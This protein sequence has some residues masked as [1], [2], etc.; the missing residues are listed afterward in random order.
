MHLSRLTAYGYSPAPQIAGACQEGFAAAFKV[1]NPLFH[2]HM[3]ALM[4]AG[5][6]AKGTQTLACFGGRAFSP[7][8]PF[9]GQASFQSTGV[10]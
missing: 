6:K 4:G 3:T 8:S 10:T 5:E 7:T 9:R 1:I 2:G